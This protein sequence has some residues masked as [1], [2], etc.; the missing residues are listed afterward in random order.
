MRTFL[1]S[2][3]LL[4]LI[5]TYV[6]ATLAS[7]DA[8]AESQ[9]HDQSTAPDTTAPSPSDEEVCNNMS[10]D[11]EDRDRDSSDD[12]ASRG[13]RSSRSSSSSSSGEEDAGR[14]DSSSDPP[15]A[16]WMSGKWGISWRL[17]AGDN[18]NV[19]KFDVDKLVR[20]VQ[21]I[22]HCSYV[23]FGLSNGAKGGTYIAPHSVLSKINP[24]TV[25]ERDLFGELATAFQGAG[26]KVLVYMATE[27][28]AQLKHKIKEDPSIKANWKAHVLDIY[29]SDDKKTLMK[30]YAE[31]IVGE[32]AQRYGSKIDG[33]WFDHCECGDIPRLHEVCKKA[34][35]KCVMAFNRGQKVPLRNN[36][37]GY[38]DYTFGHPTPVKR[39]PPSTQKN[40]P[41]V[42]SIEK[43]TSD[44]FFYRKGKA[45]LGHMFMPMQKKWNSGDE[46]L[47]SEEQAVDWM[48]RV[49]DAGGAWT[50]NVPILDSKSCLDQEKK[51]FARRVGRL[52]EQ[53]RQGGAG[54]EL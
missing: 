1:T 38:E 19:R 43:K 18:K 22:D 45:S 53:R 4:L 36:N 54:D 26:Y 15:P 9:C 31:I 37:P 23:L 17:V 27:G 49:L 16:A 40:L 8:I 39:D 10:S 20:D 28:P 41:M 52:L 6:L 47:W 21:G 12:E 2:S 30:A 24:G 5:I 7:S 42:E 32:Y 34:N 29:G 44:G 48:G 25:P 50:W 46:V 3:L 51:K 11:E 13:S 33:W 14:G 35:P